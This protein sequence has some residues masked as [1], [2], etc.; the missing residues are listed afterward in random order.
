MR[1]YVVCVG[2]CY[3]TC[4]ACIQLSLC[5]HDDVCDAVLTEICIMAILCVYDDAMAV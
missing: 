4:V 1:C 5:Y 2:L 3:V